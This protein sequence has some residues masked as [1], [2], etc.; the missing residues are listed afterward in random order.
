MCWGWTDLHE[1][2]ERGIPD[3]RRRVAELDAAHCVSSRG[4]HLRRNVASAHFAVRGLAIYKRVLRRAMAVEFGAGYSVGVT[5]FVLALCFCRSLIECVQCAV[6][7]C[8]KC[9]LPC[10]YECLVNAKTYAKGA[11]VSFTF[12]QPMLVCGAASLRHAFSRASPLSHARFLEL[13]AVVNAS[14]LDLQSHVLEVDMR[15]TALPFSAAVAV[16][17]S[18]WWHLFNSGLFKHDP[19]WNE[20]LFFGDES[21]SIWSY[22]LAYYLELFCMCVALTTASAS[23]LSMSEALYMSTTLTAL[24]VYFAAAARY[25]NRSKVSMCMSMVAFSLLTAM[26]CS[27]VVSTVDTTCA[28]PAVCGAAL[29]CALFALAVVHYLA[30]GSF[31]AGDIILLRTVVSNACVLV[32][33]GALA[34][35]RSSAC[36]T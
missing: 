28:V 9:Q 1:L 16:S 11:L 21:E 23:L 34:A 26:L 13:P 3:H 24:L 7:C 27:F 4:A 22:E 33:V 10:S 15:F 25:H 14:A 20:E 12:V 30:A 8:D 19:E 36:A 32:L 18:M 2:V 35:G 5:V 31:T 17:A 29:V 6:L